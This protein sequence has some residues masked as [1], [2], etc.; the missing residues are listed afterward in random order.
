MTLIKPKKDVRASILPRSM[1]DKDFKRFSEFVYNECGIKLT[2]A[3][4]TMVQ[5]RLQKRLRALGLGGYETYIEYLFSP[6]GIDKELHHLID[7]VTTNTTEFF[8]EPRHFD[9]LVNQVLPEWTSSRGSGAM[10]VWS[11][12]CSSG[13]EPYT[14]AMVLSDFAGKSGGFRFKIL[15]T[16]ISN[17]VLQKAVRG[18][19]PADR[20]RSIPHAFKKD[21]LLRSKERGSNLV[22]MAPDIRR[23]VRF[24]R[25][26]FMENF[27]LQ[28]KMDIIFCRNVIIY[29]DNPTQK[30]VL[31]RFCDHLSQGGYL[32]I[33]H[34]ESLAGMALPLTQVAP[35]IY[36]KM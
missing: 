25:L 12:G 7:V 9:F 16:D 17:Q 26:N 1:R 24:R 6:Q 19:Y 35:T 5:A 31:N 2:A 33:G 4:K 13:E 32:F 22:R 8:R 23:L 30:I 28:E 15:A 27:G 36:C 18:I 34:S 20:A 21:Y 3:K 10:S 11:A 14:L 29:F